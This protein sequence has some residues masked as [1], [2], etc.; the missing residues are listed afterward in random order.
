MSGNLQWLEILKNN[1]QECPKVTIRNLSSRSSHNNHSSR[2][3]NPLQKMASLVDLW[4]LVDHRFEE[5]AVENTQQLVVFDI[6]RSNH[7]LQQR[8]VR[9][10]TD[11][12]F[13]WNMLVTGL[14]LWYFCTQQWHGNTP[15]L[16]CCTS[17]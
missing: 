12:R 11:L 1:H 7:K 5:A 4:V 6:V 14:S 2:L 8:A 13:T 3:K 17:C 16:S 10:R 9:L 15:K